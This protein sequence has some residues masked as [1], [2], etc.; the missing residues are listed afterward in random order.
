MQNSKCIF[1]ICKKYSCKS[2]CLLCNPSSFLDQYICIVCHIYPCGIGCK[3]SCNV[4]SLNIHLWSG[5]LV[6]QWSSH[7][8][9]E[10]KQFRQMFLKFQ[11]GFTLNSPGFRWSQASSL[12]SL[13]GLSPWD[14][15]A[16]PLRC[17]HVSAH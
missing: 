5:E 10:L 6:S 14:V 4:Q 12:A 7:L 3:Q 13:Q 2:L 11:L 17:K 1:I 15:K 8:V 9:K 16:G